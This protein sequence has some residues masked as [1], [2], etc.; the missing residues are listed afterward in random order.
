MCIFFENFWKVQKISIMCGTSNNN[1]VPRIKYV[2]YGDAELL[3]TNIS[4]SSK[5]SMTISTLF[6]KFNLYGLVIAWI[7][8]AHA[9][10]AP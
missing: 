3:V 7:Q 1:I 9:R 8:V 5:T 10:N 6:M 4:I 2:R